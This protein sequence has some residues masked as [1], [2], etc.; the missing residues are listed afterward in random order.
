[1]FH[2]K[3]TGSNVV[4]FAAKLPRAGQYEIY[5]WHSAGLNRAENAPFTVI[6][7]GGTNR[8]EVNQ[9]LNGSRW[10]L[11][12]T[13]SFQ[14]KAEVRVSDENFKGTVVIADAI[15]F[16]LVSTNETSGGDDLPVVREAADTQ[17]EQIKAKQEAVFPFL[18]EKFQPTW[19][20]VPELPWKTKPMTGLVKGTVTDHDGKPVYNAIIILSPQN[21]GRAVGAPPPTSNGIFGLRGNAALPD[22]RIQRTEPHGKFAFFDVAPGS[23]SLKA[24][25]PGKSAAWEQKVVVEA[26]KIVTVDL[27]AKEKHP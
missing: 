9:K 13:F 23:Y 26:G 10:N 6:H 24:S 21:E 14:T 1:L 7:Q 18:K 3:G 25:V 5:E 12:G 11:L 4:T 27:P 17:W 16:V 22:S 8:V 2:S 20:N 19:E 15:K